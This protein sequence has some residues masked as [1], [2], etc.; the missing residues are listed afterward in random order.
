[1]LKVCTVVGTR[2]EL[3]KLSR[4]IP[5][6]DRYFEH[7][8]IHTN[9]NYDDKLNDIFFTEMN[10][11]YP[12]KH[13]WSV[14]IGQPASEFVGR[15]ITQLGEEFSKRRPDAVLILGDTNSCFAAAYAAKRLR[16]PLFHMEAGN[17]CFDEH[18]PEEINRRAID[19]ISDINL[20]YS[21]A[22]RR[23]LLREGLP[24][25][26]VIKT[27]SPM[28]EV[29][30]YYKV[31]IDGSNI[32]ERE[33]LTPRKYFLVSCHR[34][35]NINEN[36]G[37]F[38]SL[39]N[40]L[41]E[42]YDIPVMVSTHPRVRSQIPYLPKGRWAS[43][44]IIFHDPLG[45]FDYVKLQ[46]NARVVLSDSGTITEETSILGFRALN[47]RETH[48]RQEGMDEAAVPMVGL[49]PGRVLQGIEFL[50]KRYRFTKIPED[51]C[52]DNVSEKIP[53]IILSY[54]DYVRRTVYGQ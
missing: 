36:S 21:E 37:A 7:T 43:S 50:E 24:E 31:W 3:I 38:L 26:R 17:R 32:L 15:V 11:R 30:D 16:I 53:T 42:A 41:D 23:N 51:Y 52:V 44:K 29:S 40:E 5:A 28:K 2:P 27:G 8:L 39:L 13:L 35:E 14:N 49:N 1:V 48:E 47:I 22:A 10:I 25:D 6:L 4:V 34:E 33:N 45:F 54:V 18:V 12:D 20:P 19:H 9:Q 46:Q